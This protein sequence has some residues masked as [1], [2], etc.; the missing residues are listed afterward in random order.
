MRKWFVFLFLLLC[1]SESLA[2]SITTYLLEPLSY[3]N[4][5]LVH[6]ISSMRLSSSSVYLGWL[7]QSQWVRIEIEELPTNQSWVLSTGFRWISIHKVFLFDENGIPISFVSSSPFYLFLPS[8]RSS[9][10]LDMEIQGLPL[11]IAPRLVLAEKFFFRRS[12]L[13]TYVGIV[14]GAFF[15]LL[16]WYLFLGIRM[17]FY[18]RVWKAIN[19]G[20]LGIISFFLMFPPVPSLGWLLTFVGIFGIS[21]TFY[22]LVAHPEI[23]RPD[24]FVLYGLF[25]LLLVSMMVTVWK[26]PF[27]SFLF[28]G[29]AFHLHLILLVFYHSAYRAALSRKHML[30]GHFSLAAITLVFFWEMMG[31]WTPFSPFSPWVFSLAMLLYLIFEAWDLFRVVYLDNSLYQFYRNTNRLLKSHLAQSNRKLQDTVHI[32]Q[33]ESTRKA[34]LARLYEVEEKKY[35]DLVE[36]LSDWIWEMDSRFIITYTSP[37]IES[38]LGISP[39]EALSHHLDHIFGKDNVLSLKQVLQ[40]TG[41]KVAGHTVSLSTPQ[42][43][44]LLEVAATPL[45]REGKRVGY[46]CIGR[47]V[48]QLIA[49]RTDIFFYKQNL[50]L[51]F[52]KSPMAIAFLDIS[53]LQIVQWNRKFEEYFCLQKPHLDAFI[54]KIADSYAKDI[55]FTLKSFLSQTERDLAFLYLPFD[56]QG[57]ISWEVMQLY[58]VEK[59]NMPFLVLSLYPPEMKFFDWQ[60]KWLDDCPIPALIVD[61][62]GKIIHQNPASQKENFEPKL[63]HLLPEKVMVINE[64]HCRFVVIPHPPF[65]AFVFEWRETFT[66]ND[67]LKQM[68]HAVPVPWLITDGDLNVIEWHERV[69]ECFRFQFPHPSFLSQMLRESGVARFLSSFSSNTLQKTTLYLHNRQGEVFEKDVY[70][71]FFQSFFMFFFFDKDSAHLEEEWLNIF[72]QQVTSFY[73]V[74]RDLYNELQNRELFPPLSGL[75]AENIS[76]PELQFLT[77]TERKIFDLVILGK[78][79]AEIAHLQGIVEETVKGHIKRIFKKLG[80]QKRYQLIQR[81][82]GK[83]L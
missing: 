9:L 74:I 81:Y 32:L 5:A 77:E 79:N 71:F 60:W 15:L 72:S 35:R 25:G 13:S 50:A 43:A 76:F 28:F 18:Q 2:I 69:F 52:E 53:T 31:V 29:I 26:M 3:T 55:Y 48:T 45:V 80:V 39:Q 56:F 75:S 83:G 37:R 68:M 47:D 65:L 11:V 6:E 44:L 24:M 20:M 8:G 23:R 41:E 51:L 34:Q 66:K 14:C 40:R 64:N 33:K 63:P 46:R 4:G 10:T 59:D 21:W 67:Y 62:Y 38:L 49:M 36:N 19:F 27:V 58:K 73:Q 1:F 30:P 22:Q 57:I 82:H 61:K 12:F 78:S 17:G 7:T 54:E 42:G 16:I 70:F